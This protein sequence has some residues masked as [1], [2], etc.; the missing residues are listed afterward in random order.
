MIK[1]FKDFKTSQKGK[2][3]QRKKKKAINKSMSESHFESSLIT[4]L[5]SLYNYV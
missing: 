4:K 2:R 5:I 1:I 3:E